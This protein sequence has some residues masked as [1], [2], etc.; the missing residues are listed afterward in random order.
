MQR[1]ICQKL[2][3]C[4]AK[5][6]GMQLTKIDLSNLKLVDIRHYVD[7]GVAFI[8]DPIKKPE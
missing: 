3:V 1:F 8:F 4:C 7:G 6:L 5:A 2:L